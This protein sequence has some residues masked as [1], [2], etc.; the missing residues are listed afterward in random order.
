MLIKRVN[1]WWWRSISQP[2]DKND[3][4]SRCDV[5]WCCYLINM[6]IASNLNMLGKFFTNH[7][8]STI[9]SYVYNT[10]CQLSNHL[11]QG[12][13]SGCAFIWQL[14]FVYQFM[15]KSAVMYAFRIICFYIC[16]TEKINTEN[17]FFPVFFTNVIFNISFIYLYT[18]KA[19]ITLYF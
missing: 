9:F 12:I 19:F 18:H 13:F 3:I 17:L 1:D 16:T 11:Q 15:N 14:M 10:Q 2:T 5:M 6:Q 8:Y 4:K 7:T